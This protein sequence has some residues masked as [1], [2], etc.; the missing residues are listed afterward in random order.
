M[1]FYAVVQQW[2][3]VSMKICKRIIIEPYALLKR[4]LQ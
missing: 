4:L 2:N 3:G 1:G